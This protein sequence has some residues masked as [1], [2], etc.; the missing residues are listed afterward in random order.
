MSATS[1]VTANFDTTFHLN[2]DRVK[3]QTKDANDLRVQKVIFA[4]GAFS[5]WHHHPGLVLAAV[6]SGS[7]TVWDDEC[8]RETYGPGLPNGAVFVEGGDEPMQVTSTGGA[9]E[10]VTLVAPDHNPPL[11]R[12]EDDPP[13]CAS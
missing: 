11:F 3:F 13:P 9:T 6:E 4:A 2:S 8:N 1:F 7:V 5:G 12:V 10:Y